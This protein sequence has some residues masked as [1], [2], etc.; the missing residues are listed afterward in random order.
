MTLFSRSHFSSVLS[1]NQ[2]RFAAL[3]VG[4]STYEFGGNTIQPITMTVYWKKESKQ[5][6]FTSKHWYQP[7]CI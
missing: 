3:G 5:L 6:K 2:S 7:A 4:N 1:A